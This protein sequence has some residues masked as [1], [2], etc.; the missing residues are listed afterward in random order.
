MTFNTISVIESE[1][2]GNAWSELLSTRGNV[3]IPLTTMKAVSGSAAKEGRQSEIIIA[4]ERTALK[5]AFNIF[6]TKS[7]P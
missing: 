5:N 2:G 7:S 6:F 4:R 3:F 1:D